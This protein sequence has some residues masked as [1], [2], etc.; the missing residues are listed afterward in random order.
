MILGLKRNTVKLINHNTKWETTAAQTIKQL[1]NI[2]GSVAKDIQHIGS[3]AIKSIKAKP[4]IDIAIAVDNFE[5]VEALTPILEANGFMHRDWSDEGKQ[6]LYAVGYDVPVNDRVTTHYIHVVET[7]SIE[8]QN[9]VNFR[10]YLNSSTIVATNYEE[11]KI[12]LAAENP[13]DI[14]RE[15]YLA[16]KHEF[17][18]RTLADAFIWTQIYDIPDFDNFAHIEPITKGWS[19]DKKYC[20]T[21]ENGTR[22]LLRITPISRY[23]T[24]KSLF[25][26]QKKVASLNIPMCVPIEFGT[27]N[28][29]VY[30]L[31]S[32]IYGEDLETVLPTLSDTQAYVLGLKSGEILRKMHSIP[33]P[34]SQEDWETRFNNKTN[35]QIEKYKDCGLRFDGDE[36]ILNYI[37]QNRH[38]LKNRP[39]CFQHGDYHIGNMMVE[40]GELRII[41][42]D[43][44]DFGDP[45]EEFN[46]IVWSADENP[47]FATGQLRGYFDGER[48][49]MGK[50][51]IEFYKLLA[52]YIASN[53]LSSIYWAIPFG[54]SEIDTMMKQSQDVLAWYDNMKN[55]VPTWYHKDFYIQ[56]ADGIP[57]KLS[58]PY[59]F[60][61]L[62]KYGK[63]FKVFDDQDSGNICF[64][65]VDIDKRIFVKFAGAPTTRSNITQSEV[66]KRMKSTI[67]V[68]T[69]LSHPILTDLLYTEEVG[70][71]IAC[72]F[73]W[74]D[75]KCMGRQYPES[76]EQFLQ[77]SPEAKL[78]MF[79]DI[80]SFHVH[81]AKKGYVAIDFYDGCIMY[82][83][84]KGKTT[85]CDIE[86]YKKSSVTNTM[87]RM[88]GSSRFMSPEEFQLGATI[89]EI[90]NVYT[91]GAT[92]FELF[93]DNRERSLDKWTLSKKLYDIAIKAVSDERDS[94]QQ[95]IEQFLSEWSFAK[96]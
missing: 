27:C 3:T 41:D 38:L 6:L 23:E 86:M 2:L 18:T 7:G 59:D 91:M 65:I 43:R 87:G 68:Y 67:Q 47:H 92:A 94:R 17:I 35:I 19:E 88:Y 73:D 79:D 9:Y 81:V 5:D 53:T 78:Q 31:Q 80:L 13:Y 74:L 70:G 11:I 57:Y 37:E 21:K 16:G 62:S 84:N 50:P 40:N 8:W 33:A 25:E 30:S 75:A 77:S 12:K 20:I 34:K 66:I 29:G 69:D 63:V 15:K 48:S 28:G 93:G 26:M 22:Y 54:Q 39:Q 36:H 4:I 56:W 71:G 64:G 76:R 60:S 72:V 32:W 61:F 55:F 1:W 95:S 52:F 44:Y 10:D 14:G 46:R 58:A 51:P 82:D 89:D 42:F 49:C 85:I 83:F 45:W 96:C 24:R 90:T